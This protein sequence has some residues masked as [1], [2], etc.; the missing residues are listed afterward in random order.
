MHWQCAVIQWQSIKAHVNFVNALTFN[1][2]RN[3]GPFSKAGD[4]ERLER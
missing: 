3:L 1:A 4:I 2:F